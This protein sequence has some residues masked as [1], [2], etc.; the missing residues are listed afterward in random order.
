MRK[1]YKTK[2][3]KETNQ[4]GRDLAHELTGGEVILLIG[5]IGAG[6]TTFVQGMAAALDVRR[7]IKS[8]TF[9]IVNEHKTHHKKIKTLVH[10][11]GYRLAGS[12]LSDLGIDLHCGCADT[13][14]AIEWPENLKFDLSGCDPAYEV[15]IDHVEGDRRK[16]M[17]KE[18]GTRNKGHG[19][20][21]TS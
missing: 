2:N 21:Q 9:T 8:P 3:A 11:D 13:V 15:R 17:I 14:I 5:E 1:D 6:K 7:T 20:K 12:S 4:L 16:V 10:L 18:Q 19:R